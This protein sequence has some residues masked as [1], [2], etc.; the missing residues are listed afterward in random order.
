MNNE[1]IPK[2]GITESGDPCFDLKWLPWVK[3]SNPTILI[4]KNPLKLYN[5]IRCIKNANLIVHATI[6]GNGGT[7]IEP[8]VPNYKEALE[9]LYKLVDLL[10]KERVVLRIDPIIPHKDYFKNSKMVLDEAKEHLKENMCRVRIS[11]YD[12]YQHSKDRLSLVGVEFKH[13]SFNLPLEDRKKIIEYFGDVEVCG[14]DGIKSTPCLSEKDCQILGVKP[15][16][17]TKRQRYN[18]HC[19][20]NKFELLK[21]TGSQC[22]HQCK[23][24]F[25]KKDF[26]PKK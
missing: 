2:I 9:G 23:Y 24:C 12:N 10:G 6:T 13:N 17:V 1:L 8:N 25:W 18:C 15:G 22:E 11:I 19:L 14:E 26:K 16:I 7:I 21:R 3:L 4:T 20:S 5:L